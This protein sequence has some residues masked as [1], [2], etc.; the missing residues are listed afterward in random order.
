MSLQQAKKIAD[1]N[2]EIEST[3]NKLSSLHDGFRAQINA[4]VIANFIDHLQAHDFKVVKT[5]VGAE[6][7]YKDL[8]I[9]LE[10][11]ASDVRYMGVYHSF[12]IVVNGSKRDVRVI[13]SLTGKPDRPSIRTGD[14]VTLLEQDLQ[15]YKE[16]LAN[17]KMTGY[18]FDCGQKVQGNR[19]QAVPKN[20]I[21]EVIDV[22]LV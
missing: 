13:V 1:L 15:Q 14:T 20:T 5:P 16:E 10:L 17:V 6:A 9:K 7:N 4:D 8:Q 12:E 19:I 11:A 2:A 18:Y 3:S 21:A 22:F